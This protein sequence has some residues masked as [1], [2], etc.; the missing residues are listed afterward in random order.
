MKRRTAALVMA[1]LAA[2]S[3][4][5]EENFAKI[6]EGMTEAQVIA[7]LGKPDEASSVKVLGV[8]GTTARWEGHG[9]V[10]TVRF[11]NG[12]VALKSFDKPPPK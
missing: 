1:L 3:N 12:Q 9:A 11:V 5:S 10:I 7:I 4:V 2:C 6:D 8:S